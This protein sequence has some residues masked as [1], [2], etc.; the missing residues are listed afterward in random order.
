MVLQEIKKAPF[1]STSLRLNLWRVRALKCRYTLGM[2]SAM[3]LIESY[4]DETPRVTGKGKPYPTAIDLPAARRSVVF[5]DLAH[6]GVTAGS[7]FPGL[8]GACE[9]LRQR[10]FQ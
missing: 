8:D 3:N 9:E 1:S 6:I 4:L 10:N 7:L 2:W 5:A